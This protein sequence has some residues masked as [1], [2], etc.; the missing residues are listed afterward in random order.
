MKKRFYSTKSSELAAFKKT[1]TNKLD[2]EIN[3]RERIG[4]E[5]EESEHNYEDWGR[6]ATYSTGFKEE[7]ECKTLWF[8]SFRKL[9]FNIMCV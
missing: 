5:V 1:F 8:S 9:S 7:E 4:S 3:E 2:K 6:G